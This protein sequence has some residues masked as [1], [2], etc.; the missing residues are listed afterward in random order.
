M[1]KPGSGPEFIT[2]ARVFRTQGRRGEVAVEPCSNLPG[3][4]TAGMKLLA[5]AESGSRR[6]LSVSDAWP[7]KGHLVLKFDGID[8]I[9]AAEELVGCEL[10]VPES[11]RAPLEQ[12]WTYVRDLIGCT[13]F[14]NEHEIG[15]V[16][17]VQ[18]GT[19]EAVLLIVRT[20]ENDRAV[21]YAEAYLRSLDLAHRQ[22]KMALP[23]GLLELDAPLTAE[24]KAQQ[25]KR[26][27]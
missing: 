13:L 17:D 4:F 19:G 26:G 22:I 11:Q 24:E 5:L 3:R 16:V 1:A 6:E 18:S 7:H 15:E 14:D 9:S 20:G 25:R 23:E 8:S 27:D 2:L 12:G 10:L 21:P